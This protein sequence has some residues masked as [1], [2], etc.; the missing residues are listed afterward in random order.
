MGGL[1]VELVEA[2]DGASNEATDSGISRSIGVLDLLDPAG[3]H[4]SVARTFVA[5]GGTLE[6]VLKWKM[7]VSSVLLR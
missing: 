6:L 2:S 1:D 7:S 3:V 4:S 5:A